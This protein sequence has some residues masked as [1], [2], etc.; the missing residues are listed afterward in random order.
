MAKEQLK[1]QLAMSEE[2]NNSLMLMLAKSLLDLDEV[3]TIERLF[4]EIDGIT[5]QD[6]TLVANEI[7]APELLSTL[8]YRP[9]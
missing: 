4:A 2:N 8:T 3:K 1:G 6:L 7:F 5:K 9:E